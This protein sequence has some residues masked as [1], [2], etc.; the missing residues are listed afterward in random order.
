MKPGTATQPMPPTG[1]VVTKADATRLK[2]SMGD[3]AYRAWL[4]QFGLTEER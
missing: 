4:K 2:A 3:T 1:E